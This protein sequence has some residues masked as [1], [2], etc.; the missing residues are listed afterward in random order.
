VRF[1]REIQ[2]SEKCGDGNEGSIPF[3]RSNF[4]IAVKQRDSFK[5]TL[6]KPEK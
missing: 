5:F 1:M 6:L 4:R 3:T 2:Q